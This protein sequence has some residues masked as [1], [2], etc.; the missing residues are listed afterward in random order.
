MNRAHRPPADGL[1]NVGLGLLA[2]TAVLA[3]LLRLAG[4]LAAWA[5][6]ADQPDVGVAAALGV[7][8]DPLDPATALDA[9]GLHPIVYW[10]AVTLLLA[11]LAAA[12][13]GVWR[14]VTDRTKRADPRRLAGTATTGDIARTASAKTLFKH[15]GT[16]RPSLTSGY[17]TSRDPLWTR[18]RGIASAGVSSSAGLAVLELAVDGG[19]DLLGTQQLDRVHRD[20]TGCGDSQARCRSGLVVG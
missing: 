12:G 2:A 16:L 18:H 15:A 7:L 3:E 10:L 5:S 8:A 19:I 11:V 14:M 13:W 1:V 20:G 9:P 4:T 17:R 6:G